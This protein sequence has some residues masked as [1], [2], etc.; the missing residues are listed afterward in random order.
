MAASLCY[1]S[2]WRSEEARYKFSGRGRADRHVYDSNGIQQAM[3]GISALGKMVWDASSNP[4]LY[5]PDHPI[6]EHMVAACK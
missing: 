1:Y 5:P 2:S 6:S 3:S 4:R